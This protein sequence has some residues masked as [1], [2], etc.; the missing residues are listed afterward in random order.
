VAAVQTLSRLNRTFPPLKQDAMVLDFVNEQ[1][2]IKASFQDY[3]QRTDLEGATD[4][5]K[6]TLQPE[7]C[8]GADA[9]FY[10]R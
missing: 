2:V 5:N 10:A 4:P 1:E 6:L 7:I 3:Y 8:A 9:G